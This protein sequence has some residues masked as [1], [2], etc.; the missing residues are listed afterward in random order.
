VAGI[1]AG[2]WCFHVFPYVVNDIIDLP[3]D[4]TEPLR[5]KY[6]LVRGEVRQRTAIAI[7][8]THLILVLTVTY[9]LLVSTAAELTMATALALMTIY[10]LWG[11]KCAFPPATDFI[12]GLAWGA[13][14][15]WGT[16]V[17]GGSIGMDTLLVL[18][19]TTY[20][21][22]INGVHGSLRDLENDGV[23]GARTTALLL[24]ARPLAEGVFFLPLRGGCG[25]RHDS[26]LC[27]RGRGSRGFT[28]GG[29]RSGFLCGDDRDAYRAEK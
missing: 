18:N 16:L 15:V 12:Q 7:A 3:I 26:A 20:I 19:V 29:G 6:P 24:G 27:I 4:R 2:A 9:A 8:V 10:N 1:L 5:T 23:V 11:K 21:V 17:A 28:A 14:S 22:L 13:L 25:G